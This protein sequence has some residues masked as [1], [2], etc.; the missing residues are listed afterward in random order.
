MTEHEVVIA[1]GGP[2]GLM[3]AAELALARVDVAVVERREDQRVIG[4]R[5]GGLH[6]RT[7]EVL[8]QRGVVDRFLTE[9]I[10][11]PK[12]SFVH[13]LDI[14]DQP[15]RHN[16]TLGLWQRHIERI[17][18]DWVSE[19]SVPLYPGREVVDFVQDGAGVAVILAD[20]QHLQSQYLVACDGGRSVVRKRAGI[21]FAG[22]DAS[23]SYLLAE[24]EM[25]EEPEYGMRRGELGVFGI[26]KHEDGEGVRVVLIEPQV[27]HGDTPSVADIREGLRAS[28]GSDFGFH[29]PRWLS[30]FSDAA[31][32][33]ASY[34]KG[35][36]LLAGD[37]AHVHSPVGGQ[38]LNT[39]VQDAVNLGWKLAQVVHGH[40]S[41]RLL[42][43]YHDER[44]PVAARVLE[45]TLAMT[46]LNRGDAR[47]E[48]A[49]E[50]LGELLAMEQ[51]RRRYA[52]MMAGLDI[53]YDLGEG[54]ALL[55]RRVPDLELSTSR[56]PTRVFEL[57]HEARAVLLNLQ[58]PRG[59]DLSRWNGRV[60]QVEARYSGAWE[61][62]GVGEVSAPHALLIRPDGHVAW[63]GEDTDAGLDDALRAWLGGVR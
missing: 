44:H 57:L 49:R 63:V 26:G 17:L 40:S 62:P 56:G 5:A 23:V 43:T 55:G 28:Y 52:A 14:G 19:L 27:R 4:S 46:A 24:G 34:R 30:R 59:F 36:V 51:P 10:K 12:V 13:Q 15:T 3:L 22:W 1:G 32:Q 18:A 2:T 60:R 47:T 58:D 37:A 35:R 31:R 9:G 21:D 39:G 45:H 53:R 54:H 7:L 50:A 41:E 48:A 25:R 61:L 16:Y 6:S 42:D 8:D 29:S 11:H 33:A 38:G 20:G